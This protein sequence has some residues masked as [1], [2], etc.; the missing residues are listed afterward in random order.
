AMA[1]YIAKVTG[2]NDF[3]IGGVN[4]NRRGKKEHQQMTGMFVSTFPIRVK[5][6]G[7]MVFNDFVQKMAGDITGILKRYQRY[8]FDVLAKELRDETGEDVGSLLNTF[9]V[10]HSDIKKE[11]YSYDYIFPEEVTN[12]LTL[13]INLSNRDQDGV[14]Q[15]EWDYHVKQFY[16]SDIMRIHQGLVNVL[17][18]VLRHP[19]KVLA[20]VELLSREEKRQILHEFNS[21]CPTVYEDILS[22]KVVCDFLEDGVEKVPKNTAL[23]CGTEKMTYCQL[24]HKANQLAHA[25]KKAGVTRDYL[26]GIMIER[27]PELVIGILAVL[28]AGGAYLPLAPVYSF[29]RK[30]LLLEDSLCKLLLTSKKYTDDVDF[31]GTIIDLLDES[32]YKEETGNPKKVNTP[33][34]LAYVVYTS[35]Y[36]GEAKGIMVEHISMLNTLW[37][38][39]RKYPFEESDIYL[40]KTSYQYDVSIP[41]LFTWF[42]G[43]GALSILKP[44]GEED[45]LEIL[46]AIQRDRVTHVN[47]VPTIF[48]QFMNIL[49][50]DNVIRLASLK[51]LFLSGEAVVSESITR[52]VDLNTKIV[53]EN[54][55]SSPTISVYASTYSISRWHGAG[56]IPIGRPVNNTKIY[57]CNFIDGAPVLVPV[58]APGEL[59]IS[60]L[61]LARGYLKNPE[62]TSERFIP[63]P[64]DEADSRFN[65]LYRTGEL[66]RWFP[67]GNIEY[68]GRIDQQIMMKN[69]RID[70]PEIE[71]R[72]LELPALKEAVVV[73]REDQ[74]GKYLCAYFVAEEAV[75]TSMERDRLEEKLPIHMIPAYFLQIEKM[76]LTPDGKADRLEL[77]KPEHDP[78][79]VEDKLAEIEAEVLHLNKMDIH[80]DDNFFN[81]GG[82]SHK[83]AQVA[84]KIHKVFNVKVSMTELFK[85]PT[86]RQLSEFLTESIKE[87]YDAIEPAA[88]KAFYPQSAAQRRLFFLHQLEEE[89]IVYN[90]QM[91]DIYCKGIERVQLEN[92]FKEL[93]KR[94]ESL[95]TS[96]HL[97]DE[98]PVQKIHDYDEV[99]AN[100]AIEYYETTEEGKIF[101]SDADNSEAAEKEGVYFEEVI[102]GFV[103]PFDLSKAPLLR[104]GFIKILGNTKILMLDMHHIVADG[105]SMEILAKELWELYEDK[106][107]EP[108][109]LQYKDFSEWLASADRMATVAEQEQF[110]L[111]EF[112]GEIPL[113]NLPTDFPRPA[114]LTFDGDL[115]Q[116][117]I[118]K[119]ETEKLNAIALEHNETLYMVLFSIF[120]VLLCKLTGQEDIVVGTVTA[121]RGHADLE[122]IVGM[123][124]NT[125]ALRNHPAG[126]KKFED[127]L[128]EV[129]ISAFASFENQ[130][131]PFDTLVSKV[132]P[133]QDTSRNPLFDVSFGLENEADPTGYLMEVAV[134]DKSKPFDFG[135]NKAKF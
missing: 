10:G 121:G 26:V 36:Y 15:F 81:L 65:K 38:L 61:G 103:R 8:P 135:T 97:H 1:V 55:Y 76:P 100:F 90:I 3:V 34:D 79:P 20:E 91:M 118:G 66:A 73:A 94:H 60:G 12:A 18:D 69:I 64:F 27:S 14:L 51:Y 40:L 123:F 98:K 82:H 6:D 49:N 112:D 108:L 62:L 9:V 110:W 101:S 102:K 16:G 35:G 105:I 13:H 23:I 93:I 75:D 63:N 78:H 7:N 88:P 25:L 120:N 134:P 106:K 19:E 72:L 95:R 21:D 57:I 70:I 116:F 28:K 48:N 85:R 41:E 119:K 131:Y 99:G 124:L 74:K 113:I 46:D 96:F 133:R 125:L 31:D 92:A 43:G 83:A 80:L 86:L 22:N 114:N 37:T 68:M 129:K 2:I 44:G 42:L 53:V 4:H 117:E 87:K 17:F 126:E 130:D 24:N 128:M 71:S 39:Q 56:S 111:R 104:A 127:F 58:G 132:A 109:K 67:D 77:L 84:S 29:E 47:F 107:I 115:F 89:D 30:Q 122:Q 45:P 33:H 54:L 52:F 5:I 32:I 50:D 59:C 11:R